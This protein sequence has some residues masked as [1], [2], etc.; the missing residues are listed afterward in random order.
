MGLRISFLC[1]LLIIKLVGATQTTWQLSKN[2]NGIKVYTKNSETT[3]F[4]AIKV[5]G[6]F[7]GTWEKLVG[8]LMDINNQ[9]QW[10]YS[11]K[12]AYIIRK[13]SDREILYYTETAVPWPVE[14]RDAVLQMKVYPDANKILNKVIITNMPNAIPVKKGIVRVPYFNAVWEVKPIEKQ[15]LS[16]TYYL[17]MNPGGNLPSWVVNL[18]TAKGPYETFSKLSE[19]LKK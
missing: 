6:V 15:K 13:I 17:E 1:F 19:L 10:V 9:K 12:E 5:E 18:F 14:N 8:L 7:A 16:I 3:G 4:K 2:S 11:T